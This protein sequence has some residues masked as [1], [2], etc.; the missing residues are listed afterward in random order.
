MNS[1]GF[2][3]KGFFVDL[4]FFLKVIDFEVAERKLL[5]M[6]SKMTDKIS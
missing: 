1:V 6:T 5:K 3:E 2:E 4:T